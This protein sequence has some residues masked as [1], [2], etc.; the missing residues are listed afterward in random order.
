MPGI[1]L[2]GG[3]FDPPHAAHVEQGTA[4]L[5][6]AMPAGSWLVVVPAARSPFKKRAPGA[7]DRDRVAMLRAAFAGVK[8]SAVWTDEIDRARAAT[9]RAP[10]YWIDTLERLRSALPRES[11]PVLR[12]LIGSDQAAEFN[13]WRRPREVI[14]L[15]EPL[16]VLRPPVRTALG[17]RRAMASAGFWT[18]PELDAWEKRV[19]RCR[20]MDASATSVREQLKAKPATAVGEL[21][22]RVAEYIE[23]RGLYR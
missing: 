13:R 1:L 14:G 12:F 22:R 3:T 16:V 4:A 17:L 20:L 2:L 21:P 9:E 23:R 6:R 8:R 11:A 15:A 18:E 19:V 10:S 7:S 5:R